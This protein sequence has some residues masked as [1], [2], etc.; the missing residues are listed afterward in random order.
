LKKNFPYETERPELLLDIV[1]KDTQGVFFPL[2]NQDSTNLV[3]VIDSSKLTLSSISRGSKPSL[4]CGIFKQNYQGNVPLS[5]FVYKNSC[6]ELGKEED[7]GVCL[8]RYQ[9][10]I[11][12]LG[13]NY[14]NFKVDSPVPKYFDVTNWFISDNDR[15]E[16]TNEPIEEPKD[17]HKHPEKERDG[18]K[19][20]T[21]TKGD[22][23]HEDKHQGSK[24]P[25]TLYIEK[26]T[27]TYALVLVGLIIL[28]CFGCLIKCLCDFTK[29][30]QATVD[31][32]QFKHKQLEEEEGENDDSN[33][34]SDEASNEDESNTDK[35]KSG[36]SGDEGLNYP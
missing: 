29:D 36:N 31:E 23:V 5:I 3:N 4:E 8:Y 13:N 11:N 15:E 7:N 24:D 33:I 12:F 17:E 1:K 21:D 9:Y 22:K 14:K 19:G 30:S 20:K 18:T 6:P 25:D 28:T 35:G 34:P 2:I 32:G 16:S 26:I 10:N 27:N